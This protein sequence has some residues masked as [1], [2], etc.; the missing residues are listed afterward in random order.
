MKKSAIILTILI[1]AVSCS[2]S[3]DAFHGS[4]R[5][6]SEIGRIYMLGIINDIVVDNLQQMENALFISERDGTG[7]SFDKGG[8]ALTDDG[9]VWTLTREGSALKGLTITRQSEDTWLMERK[10]DYPILDVVYPTNYKMTV[11]KGESQ[12]ASHYNWDVT[13]TGDRTE[14]EGYSC[15]FSSDGVLKFS[16]EKGNTSDWDKCQGYLM[17]SVKKNN[18]AV[19][20][21]CLVLDG[22]QYDAVFRRVL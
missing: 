9:A 18:E 20:E 10:G 3:E 17:M 7:A 12:T 16:Y 6:S 14:K 2:K 1:L 5:S 4:G 13:I 11:V 15:R 22:G 21:A 19:D 8:K